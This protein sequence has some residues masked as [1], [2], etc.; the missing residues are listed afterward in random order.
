[1]LNTKPKGT[2]AIPLDDDDDDDDKALES[3][4]EDDDN[5]LHCKQKFSEKEMK[6]VGLEPLGW[7]SSKG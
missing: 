7:K 6:T 3:D 2:S 1:M 5:I 4:D